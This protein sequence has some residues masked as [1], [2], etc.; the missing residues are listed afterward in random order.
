MYAAWLF[1]GDHF[2]DVYFPDTDNW[3]SHIVISQEESGWSSDEIFLVRALEGSVFLTPPSDFF[4]ST[5]RSSL[6]H[7]I[8]LEEHN[9]FRSAFGDLTI[10]LKRLG[11]EQ[12]VFRKY[13]LET[14]TLTI[15]RGQRN[16]V[17]DSDQRLSTSH[18]YLSIR[19]RKSAVYTDQSANGTYLNGR[20]IINSTVLIHYGDVLTLPSGLKLIFLSDLLAVNAIETLQHIQ[21][22][23]AVQQEIPPMGDL[24]ENLP[25][26][27]SQY[28]RAPRILQQ[29]QN[30]PVEIEPPIAKQQSNALPTWLQ[31]GPSMTMVLPM[32]MGTMF[33][34]LGGSGR[35]PAGLIMVGT[36][37]VLAV[38]WG[39]INRRYRGRFE[40]ET[41]GQRV[42]MYQK[43]IGEMEQQLR[44]L[45]TQEFDRLT[46][47]FPNVGECAALPSDGSY[48][49]WSRM[50]SH[51]DFLHVR[52]GLGK[53]PLPSEI[54][55]QKQKLSI[56]DDPLRDEAD[57]LKA[58]YSSVD[59]APV[60]A[61]L[62]REAVVGIL[63]GEEAILFAQGL[64]MQI[65]ALHSYHDVRIAVFSDEAEASRWSWARWLPHV[66][67]SEDRQMRMVASTPSAIHE[68]MNHIGDLINMRR[69]DEDE[70][71]GSAPAE[72]EI[73]EKALPLPHHIL[74]C[75]NPNLL[76]N[77]PV[78]RTLLTNHLGI[79]LVMVAPS[80][81]FLPK[82]CHIIFNA[83]SKRGYLHTSD[84][85]TTQ[86][87]FEYPNRNLLQTFALQLAPLRVKDAAEN[88]AIPTMVSFL[89]I[90]GV[91]KTSELDVWRMWSENHTY[92]GL[93]SVIGF[94]AG[95]Q[96]FVLDISEKYHGPHGL[97]AG[98]TGSG[99]SVMLQTYILSLAMNYSPRQVQFI[100]IDYK[101][102]GMADAFR[103]LPHTAGIIDNLQGDRIISR[104]LASL[105][106]EIHRR[107]TLFQEVGVKD[108]TEYTKQFGENDSEAPVPH[109][110]IIT[111]EFAEL[112]SDQPEFMKEL[113][114]ASRVGRS[115]GIHLI[116][117]TQKPS[118][119]VSDE[120]WANSRF[121]LC[122]RVQTVADSRDMLKRPDAAYIK[123][124]GRCFIQIGNDESFDQVQT[125]YAGMPYNPNEPRSEELPQLLSDLGQ[126]VSVPR[127]RKKQ[128][129]AKQPTQL[130]A[131]LD[132]II[133]VADAHGIPQQRQMWLP[134]MPE[135][136]YFEQLAAFNAGRME[137]GQYPN[138][139]DG[140]QFLLGLGDD[141]AKQRYIPYMF[142]LTEARNMLLVGLSGSG[143]TTLVQ[144]IV[145][146]LA[147]RYDPSCLNMYILSLTSQTLGTLRAFPHVGDV[148]FEEETM[149][150][151]RLIDMLSR[152]S[153]RRSDLFAKASTDSFIEYNRSQKLNGQP[154]VPAI[155][156]FVDRFEQ[157]RAI[158][159]SNESVNQSVSSLIRE[160]SSR[161]IHF[162]ATA[163]SKTEVP[164][165]LHPFFEGVALQQNDRSDYS[166][167]LSK[168]VPLEMPPIARNAGRGLA[169]I[170]GELYEFQVGL[171]GTPNGDGKEYGM[172]G[173]FVIENAI[174]EAEP[175]PDSERAKQVTEF[176]EKQRALWKGPLPAGIP[177]I[178]PEPVWESFI[179]ESAYPRLLGTPF[180]AP[181]GYDLVSGELSELDLEENFSLF[182]TGPKR[183]GKTNA[184]KYLARVMKDRG[185]EVHVI[186]DSE[187]TGFA[188][189]NG[190][191]L[192]S[193]R[194]DILAYVHHFQETILR[195]DRSPKKRVAKEQGKA[196]LRKLAMELTPYTIIVDN[197]QRF[198]T[199]FNN[200]ENGA[201]LKF[202]KDVFSQLCVLA[203]HYNLQ[204]FLSAPFS[205]QMYFSQEPLKSLISM[206][207]GISMGGK[208]SDCNPLGIGN[209]IPSA[210][211][212]AQLPIG[213]GLTIFDGKVNRIVL[214]LIKSADD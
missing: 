140:V 15:G 52:V 127:R 105:N 54:I 182:V 14:N 46:S 169:A 171:A 195:D 150:V 130:E 83:A 152:E 155:V 29:P 208:V 120:I 93:R 161:G 75:T 3:T 174:A 142:N 159:E 86:V 33:G 84:G 201:E 194:D 165:K 1:F 123:G 138:P 153:Q 90:Y 59:D 197:A 9:I 102:G 5:D 151:R 87:D 211:S 23:R 65:A 126:T 25:S 99:K 124:T 60:I 80:M 115:L 196:A 45:N 191:P 164:Y 34:G 157:L 38:I 186:G 2:K 143:K 49:L 119:S 167:V 74:F 184:L 193:S 16:N 181:L 180:T 190:I 6:E 57:R 122:L 189:E 40:Q 118:A 114:S 94:S 20:R 30:E 128:T 89:D 12:L 28:H 73:N 133:E 64:L 78:M 198:N 205:A 163:L 145:Y 43:Y 109:L 96:P 100:L 56:I 129:E 91:R 166:D 107:E 50:P 131:V 31:L 172:P 47:T 209:L 117:A 21:M 112:K 13:V 26:L 110:I 70:T 67:A 68:V 79:T 139:A 8:R 168:R 77:E 111:D 212:R 183:S 85:S 192:H 210:L 103:T 37:S 97:I 116:L 58:M 214:P 42:G 22:R 207:R 178:P 62:R 48:R 213:Q 106:G 135:H 113:V 176:A 17:F 134:E 69:S 35:V 101:G 200:L 173:T 71:A 39:L 206:G 144:S 10:I 156:V 7:A 160:G 188:R 125:S 203:D 98:T 44:S 18:G 53:V 27:Y 36:S 72:E 179:Q 88:A 158:A 147:N 95:S 63:G 136:I 146:S 148:V 121:H 82:E 66:F 104:A 132:R 187:W 149:E 202:L 51:P 162:I 185:A 4:W 19:D 32:L 81:E 154:I 55:T 137:V 199:D 76:E 108:I 24:P 41:E 141:T 92:D 11:R 170:G 175:L 177:R 61:A 204:L